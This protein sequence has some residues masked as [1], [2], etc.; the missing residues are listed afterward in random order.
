VGAIDGSPVL[1]TVEIVALFDAVAELAVIA[2][3]II[4]CMLTQIGR[5]IA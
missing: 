1:A 4:R 2:R 3:A 5:F